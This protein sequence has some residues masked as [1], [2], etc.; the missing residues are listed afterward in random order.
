MFL[1]FLPSVMHLPMKEEMANIPYLHDSIPFIAGW[2]DENCHP[3]QK[4]H[5]LKTVMAVCKPSVRAVKQP[6]SHKG[7]ERSQEQ[8]QHSLEVQKISQ[9]IAIHRMESAPLPDSPG[10]LNSSL[11]PQPRK[12][13]ILIQDDVLLICT[14]FGFLPLDMVWN[15]F[16]VKTISSL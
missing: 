6:W 15:L 7:R 2:S 16:P 14:L 5:I 11:L 1:L 10:D 4:K 12:E 9:Q 13:V 8:S 3:R